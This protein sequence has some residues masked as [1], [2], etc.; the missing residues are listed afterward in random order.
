MSV[1]QNLRDGI[2]FYDEENS[3]IIGFNQL[4]FYHLL[5][6]ILLHYLDLST[7]EAREKVDNSHLFLPEIKSC[8]GIVY[9]SHEIPW[10]WAMICQFGQMYWTDHP[11]RLAPPNDYDFWE[12][13]WLSSP[14][15]PDEIFYYK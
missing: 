10:H 13:D 11:D 4:T 6:A 8:T 1:A 2:E 5:Q 9:Y 3:E 14:G 7:A 15:R 12:A